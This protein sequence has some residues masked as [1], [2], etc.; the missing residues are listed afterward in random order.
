MRAL[1]VRRAQE[2]IR[3]GIAGEAEGM[4]LITTLGVLF[5]V[6]MMLSAFVFLTRNEAFLA[7]RSRNAAIALDLAEAGVQEAVAR[8]S[9]YTVVPG[10]GTFNN[11]LTST[12]SL[13]PSAASP[14]CPPSATANSV[15]FQAPLT[16]AG[17]DLSI[18]PVCST[19]SFGSTFASAA[20]Q[21]TVRTYVLGTFKPGAA[22]VIFTPQVNYQSDVRYVSGDSYSWGFIN[23]QSNNAVI[24]AAGATAT[25][26]PPPQV[27]AGTYVFWSSPVAGCG[28]SGANMFYQYE[29]ASNS[30]TEVAPTPCAR[31]TTLPYHFHPMVPRAMPQADFITMLNAALPSGIF[32]KQATQNGVGVGFTTPAAVR[33]GAP[34]CSTGPNLYNCYPNTVNGGV[35]ALDKVWLITA[36]GT[37]VPPNYQFCVNATVGTVVPYPGSGACPNPPANLY[38]DPPP[39]AQGGPACP[40][41]VAQ[42]SSMAR[43]IDWGLVQADINKPNSPATTFFQPPMC[44]MPC[45]FPG[46]QNGIRY[47]AQP[48]TINVQALACKTNVNPGTNVVDYWGAPN[49]G[50]SAPITT[51]NAGTVTFTGTKSNPE[52][53]IILN[54]DPVTQATSPVQ[55]IGSPAP[56]P[57]VQFNCSPKSYFDGYNWGQIL[58]TGDLT[59]TTNLVF[60]GILYAQGNITFNA[61]AA[62]WGAILSPP[63]PGATSQTQFL[64]SNNATVF[65]GATQVTVL[66]PLQMNFSQFAWQD[67]TP[68]PTGT[69]AGSVYI[70]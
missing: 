21:R 62:I 13:S 25:N 39:P 29:C 37:G 32:I 51:V 23:F 45:P 17:Q 27:F 57:T 67:P 30:M 20:V 40:P 59:I 5:S 64:T 46:L 14:A 65:C 38:G 3:R 16:W 44:T 33:P 58:A 47:I 8:L 22:N 48:M 60:S 4:A 9:L 19:A 49:P 63:P 1:R 26:L 41:G 55:I 36:E 10:A 7:S 2:L 28:A 11:S 6:M 12:S 70:R 18:Y 43:Y 52:S 54:R 56:S 53:L 24:C 34:G 15:A 66:N 68:A 31:T 42:C 69:P 50:C 61:D 35:A